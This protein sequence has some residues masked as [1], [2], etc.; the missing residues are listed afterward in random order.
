MEAEATRPVPTAPPFTFIDLFAGIGG[1]RLGFEAIGGK[2]IFTCERDP[3]CQKTYAANF[4]DDEHESAKT[5]NNNKPDFLFPGQ[6]EYQDNTFPAALLTMLASKSSCKDRWRQVL[7]EAQ[8]IEK[9]HLV[10]LEPGISENQTEEM[11]AKSLQLVLPQSLHE[12][13]RDSQR[14]WL[15]NV[16]A[17]VSLVAARQA[18]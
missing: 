17:F 4:P 7:S 15:M 8:R 5:E 14:C 11:R 18:L 13:Y 9:K 2:C 16:A 12:T 1:M 10:T 6:T 3:Y